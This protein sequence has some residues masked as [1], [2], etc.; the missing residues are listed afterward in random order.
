MAV[1][2]FAPSPTGRLHVG[3]MRT[4]AINWIMARQTG[5]RFI[6]RLDDTDAERSTEAFAQ[7]IKDDMTWLGLT[8]DELER[9]SERYDRYEAERERLVSMGKLY[10][11]YETPQELETQRNL[12]KA[13]GLPPVY[14]RAALNLSDAE[15]QAL[16]AEGRRPHWRFRL[17]DEVVT[18]DDGIR[19]FVRFEPG[20]VSDPILV[21]EDGVPTYTLA[22]VIDDI[23][24]GVT[25]VVRGEDHVANTAVQIELARALGA[26]EPAYAHHSLL[27]SASGDGLSKRKGGGAVA[28]LRDDGVEPMTLMSYLARVGTSAPVEP[29]YDLKAMVS[30]FSFE[31]VSRNSPRYDPADL[32]VLNAKWL[33]G[34]PY[35]A[36]KSRVG[37]VDATFW[38]LVRGNVE[39][40]ADAEDWW[41]V[42]HDVII[43]VITNAA[44]IA[45]AAALLP[46]EPWDETTW[47]TWTGAVTDATGHKG[48]ALFM[49]LRQALTG[50]SHGPELAGLLPVIGR[51]RAAARLAGETA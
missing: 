26:T 19:G 36:V 17:G 18:F 27:A 42:C 24:M 33:H 51:D 14:D 2:R 16:E 9:Q 41:Q 15:R 37:P 4:A 5:G 47:K 49:P 8:W 7:G 32:V 48:K 13:R 3:N 6:L 31:N 10:P 38:L 29:L 30:G 45:E 21:R 46:E 40:A 50:R 39:R 35:G 11:C 22:S 25:L 43:P 44:F 12:Q 23:D 28:D 20:H 34:A 1:T